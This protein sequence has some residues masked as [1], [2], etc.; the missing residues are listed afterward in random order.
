MKYNWHRNEKGRLLL[1]NGT[2]FL[3]GG[4]FDGAPMEQPQ[5]KLQAAINGELFSIVP[6]TPSKYPT[7]S[8]TPEEQREIYEDYLW[9]KGIRDD[10][11]AKL[12]SKILEILEG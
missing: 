10:P 2:D 5:K 1:G 8:L 4:F 12:T 6:P 3:G 11:L 7:V 9:R